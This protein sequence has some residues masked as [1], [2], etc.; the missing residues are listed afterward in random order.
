MTSTSVRPP[1]SAAVPQLDELEHLL[2][3]DLELQAAYMNGLDSIGSRWTDEAL[4]EASFQLLYPGNVE[5]LMVAWRWKQ[6]LANPND[7]DHAKAVAV[8][9][10]V[11]RL[12]AK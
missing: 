2:D 8:K 5:D 6:T 11:A 10:A 9:Q 12:Q 3:I 1:H 7:P 4:A